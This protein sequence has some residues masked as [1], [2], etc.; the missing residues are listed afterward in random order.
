MVNQNSNLIVLPE[1]LAL[2][3]K[4]ELD[5]KFKEVMAVLRKVQSNIKLELSQ[6]EQSDGIFNPLNILV[7]LLSL[8]HEYGGYYVEEQMLTINGEGEV[9]WDY[10]FA[11]LEPIFI[12]NKPIYL[13]TYNRQVIVPEDNYFTRL[14]AFILT[15][16][17]QEY[18]LALEYLDLSP[19]DLVDH[20]KILTEEFGEQEYIRHRLRQEISQQ[21][22]SHK[23]EV[24]K[25]LLMYIEN[26][27]QDNENLDVCAYG[28]NSYHHVWEEVC[29]QVIGCHRNTSLKD[30]PYIRK[31]LEQE[32]KQSSPQQAQQRVTSELQQ[33]ILQEK[34]QALSSTTSYIL[35]STLKKEHNLKKQLKE[36]IPKP[37]WHFALFGKDNAESEK[38]T[39]IPDIIH[40]R[41]NAKK[42]VPFVQVGKYG[43]LQEHK[44]DLPAG[45]IEIYDAKYYN[46]LEIISESKPLSLNDITKQYLYAHALHG[47]FEQEAV[48]VNHFLMPVDID[49]LKDLITKYAKQSNG[50]SSKR[51]NEES[52]LDKLDKLCFGF[53]AGH[54]LEEHAIK[55]YYLAKV[56]FA[57]PVLYSEVNAFADENAERDKSGDRFATDATARSSKAKNELYCYGLEASELYKLYL[58][59]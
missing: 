39:F 19:V 41:A 10:T 38:A 6:V 54:M 35:N 16:L 29:R 23:L 33:S 27:S 5:N 58:L 49:S 31:Q 59:G 22:V 14:H 28:T 32:A 15:I 24:L 50:K 11:H 40:I 1:D 55:A 52:Y 12:Q 37:T 34:Q 44:L 57:L 45:C 18:S 2:Q 30:I 8:Y 46:S 47:I 7:Q 4:Q 17:S 26:I 25:L 20:T 9:D 3:G 48:K 36:L 51:D 21:F 53:H 43:S 56:N 13:D 42:D